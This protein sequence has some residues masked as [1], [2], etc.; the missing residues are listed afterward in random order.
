MLDPEVVSYMLG[1]QRRNRTLDALSAR[2]LEVLEQMAAGA[3]NHAIA[4]RMFLSQRA[5]ERHIP[6]SW[7]RSTSPLS[8]ALTDRVLAV[9]AYLHPA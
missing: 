9:L 6:R 8:S 1:R 2:D 7:K 5:I 3:S 4:V